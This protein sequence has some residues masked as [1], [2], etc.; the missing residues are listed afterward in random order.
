MPATLFHA[1]FSK[2][3]YNKLNNEIKNKIDINKLKTFSQG[4]DPL[5]FYNLISLKKGKQVRQYQKL[6]HTKDT[7]KL[8]LNIINNIDINDIDSFTF[9][10]G[11]ICH[12]VLDSNYHPYVI[13]KSANPTKKNLGKHAKIEA[14][15]DNYIISN[16][17]HKNYK[18][19]NVTK[20]SLYNFKFST[21]LNNLLDISF[22]NTY[23]INNFSKYYN[24]SIK[25][26]KFDIRLCRYDPVSIKRLIYK[27]LNLITLKKLY[28]F[29]YISYNIKIT[30]KEKSNYLN[31]TNKT[32]HNP[33]N[34]K[35]KYKYNFEDIHNNSINE[36]LYIINETYKYLT[37]NKVNLNKI[38]TNKSFMTGLNCNT[39]TKV[40]IYEKN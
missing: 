4:T 19:F 29:E 10:C 18:T 32:W 6:C 36:A 11:Y 13:Y 34:K 12:Y 22:K 24:K 21:S 28:N 25:Q 27:F 31:K 40:E 23:N 3:V 35:L 30:D 2:E 8:F 14:Y 17:L 15:F 38:Y 26:M 7:K 5:M 9:L 20:Y 16:Y 37:N 33:Y 1:Y 39:Y